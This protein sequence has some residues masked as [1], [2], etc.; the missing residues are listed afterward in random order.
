M[1]RVLT[2]RLLLM[3]CFSLAASFYAAK[4]QSLLTQQQQLLD[5]SELKEL[6][7]KHGPTSERI[8]AMKQF[9]P[10]TAKEGSESSI[11]AYK[12]E[13]DRTQLL[14]RV[15]KSDGLVSEIAW[16]EQPSTLG[17]L[18][19]DAVYDGFVPVGGNSRYY[20]RFQKLALWVNYQLAHED[21]ALPF[22]AC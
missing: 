12:R 14:V 10:V 20:N 21:G 8:L 6:L 17:N 3:A 5:Y 4:A 9:K 16:Y 11:Y 15:R 7:L 1:I 18:T 22:P 13:D 2:K 19:H